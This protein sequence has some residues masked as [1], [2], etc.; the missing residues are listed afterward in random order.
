M[1]SLKAKQGQTLDLQTLLANNIAGRVAAPLAAQMTE[2]FAKL[3][4]LRELLIHIDTTNPSSCNLDE[5]I[6]A[7]SCYLKMWSAIAPGFVFGSKPVNSFWSLHRSASTP[8]SSGKT[9]RRNTRW[10]AR[11]Q[12]WN[13]WQYCTTWRFSMG[14]E[15][16]KGHA[17]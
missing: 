13:D 2:H 1:L 5:L 7:A 10:S 8:P 17:A 11:T 15:Y 16:P 3:G 4:M 14:F 9:H 12:E 6:N